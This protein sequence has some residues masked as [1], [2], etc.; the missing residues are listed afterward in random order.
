MRTYLT[1]IVL[2]LS[3]PVIAAQ[4][5]SQWR[6]PSRD[7]LVPASVVPKTW[8]AAVKQSWRIDIGE[9]YSSPVVA[10]GRVFVHS[11]RDPEE[12]VTAVDLA[13]GKTL[14]QQK[15]SAAFQ[16]NQYAVQMA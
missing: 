16:K 3:I 9:G 5:W 11:R 14:W 1:A 10:G 2:F 13:T 7:G 4:E 12:I 15:Y 8:P 6:G